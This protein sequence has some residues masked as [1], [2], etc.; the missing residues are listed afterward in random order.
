MVEQGKGMERWVRRDQGL[1]RGRGSGISRE[2]EGAGKA[3]AHGIEGR[4]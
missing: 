1:V 4:R 3:M 2:G